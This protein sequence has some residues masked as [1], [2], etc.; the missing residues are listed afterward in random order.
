MFIFKAAQK[1]V[2]PEIWSWLKTMKF[3]SCTK[4]NWQF[5]D[6]KTEFVLTI[7]AHALYG[8]A[9]PWLTIQPRQYTPHVRQLANAITAKTARNSRLPTESG[10]IIRCTNYLL[11]CLTSLI[12]TLK[13]QQKN[14]VLEKIRF[15]LKSKRSV[16]IGHLPMSRP[17]I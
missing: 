14:T 7:R 1:Y 15:S 6:E 4:I 8:N 10:F 2:I 12:S 11:T 13:K 16:I 3:I 17:A 9:F 5:S